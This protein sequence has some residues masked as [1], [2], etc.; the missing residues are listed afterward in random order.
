L[1]ALPWSQDGRSGI[2]Y[3]AETITATD[4]AAAT[5]KTG[6]QAR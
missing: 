5:V 3:R 2:A 6:Q 4:P 1:V